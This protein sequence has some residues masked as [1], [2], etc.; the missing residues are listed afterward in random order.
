M[1]VI[2]V[3]W[4]PSTPHLCII[5]LLSLIAHQCRF[6]SFHP[7]Y[8]SCSIMKNDYPPIHSWTSWM[9]HQFFHHVVAPHRGA[10]YVSTPVLLFLGLITEI[11]ASLVWRPGRWVATCGWQGV[12]LVLRCVKFFSSLWT[13][14]NKSTW[15]ASCKERIIGLLWLEIV[16]PNR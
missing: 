10:P 5:S 12:E 7:I 3:S 4:L 13:S 1:I 6:P 11:T 15:H 2:N 9:N 14:L 8:P 16:V